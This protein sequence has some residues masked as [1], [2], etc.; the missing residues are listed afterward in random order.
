MSSVTKTLVRKLVVLATL[1]GLGSSIAILLVACGEPS[2][3]SP[4]TPRSAWQALPAAP[5]KIDQSPSG[6]WTGQQ[7]VLFGRREITARDSRGNPYVVK[8]VDAAESY[9]PASGHWTRLSPPPGPGDVPEYHAVW[10]GRE[11]LA[12]G[13]FHSV[14]YD[15]QTKSWRTLRRSVGGGSSSGPA[16]RRSVGVVAAAVMPGG[17]ALPMTPDRHVPPLRPLPAR[18]LAGPPRRLDGP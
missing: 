10:T 6:V 5:I 14:A 15:P 7:L 13:A 17:T 1:V 9:D 3:S 4:E 11:M 18:A 12:F 16:A 8:S 2:S